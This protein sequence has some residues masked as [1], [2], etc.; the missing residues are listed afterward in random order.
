MF[1]EL[2]FWS[3]QVNKIT[4]DTVKLFLY[5]KHVKQQ[6]RYPKTNF[7]F[8][9]LLQEYSTHP[10]L[11]SKD[12]VTMSSV[13]CH[14]LIFRTHQMQINL[15]ISG[16]IFRKSYFRC[17]RNNERGFTCPN[18]IETLL[19]N[20]MTLKIL[21]N[22]I[23]IVKAQVCENSTYSTFINLCKKKNWYLPGLDVT[24]YFLL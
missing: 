15:K 24:K 17:M 3:T 20:N 10:A 18:I 1:T 11:Y 19:R 8:P 4:S 7:L 2:I 22:L 6:N 21:S 16:K 14:D 13:V 5:G 23:L 12:G 9:S